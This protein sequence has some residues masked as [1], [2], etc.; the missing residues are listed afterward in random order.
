MTKNTR[1]PYELGLGPILPSQSRE[2]V[3]LAAF[4]HPTLTHMLLLTTTED[5]TLHYTYPCDDWRLHFE[6]FW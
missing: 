2:R 3:P 4:L 6:A 5:D 1:I